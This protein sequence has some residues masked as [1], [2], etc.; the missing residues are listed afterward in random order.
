ML[1]CG[2]GCHGVFLLHGA[3]DINNNGKIRQSVRL[4]FEGVYA[5]AVQCGADLQTIRGYEAAIVMAMLNGKRKR[6]L[7]PVTD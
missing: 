2:N 1:C 5:L 7:R 6:S 3:M 4:I